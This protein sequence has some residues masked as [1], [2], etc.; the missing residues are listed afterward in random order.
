MLRALDAT[1]AALE[2]WQRERFD[3]LCGVDAS[4]LAGWAPDEVKET[5]ETRREEFF[6]SMAA[7]L[8]TLA[9]VGAVERVTSYGTRPVDAG[10]IAAHG[11]L[12][13]SLAS[14]HRVVRPD[15]LAQPLAGHA[16]ALL[17]LLDR[18]A[19]DS[20]RRRLEG[21]VTSVHAQAGITAFCLG[22][23]P[24]ARRYC[25]VA[26]KVA[27]DAGDD[28]LRAQVLNVAGVLDSP[29][30][31]GELSS[32]SRRAVAT[33]RRAVHYARHADPATRA[34]AHRWLGGSYVVF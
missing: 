6:R 20:Q 11:E 30:E 9:P 18:P 32:S 15:V 25:A 7:A 21:V 29:I 34:Y 2:S 12:A 23:R 3:E 27:D 14:L 31:A 4:D 13:D 16:E 5:S 28:T 1:L 19:S 10:L 17:R 24:G 26:W 8:A 22:D 33:M